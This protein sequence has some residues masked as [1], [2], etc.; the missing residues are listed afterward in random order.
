MEDPLEPRFEGNQLVI[1]TGQET[2]TYDCQFLVAVLLVY[3][4][5][6]DG[7]ITAEETGRML[8]LIGDHFRLRSAESL[9]L[10]RRAMTDIA[11][12]PDLDSLLRELS[13]M[14]TDKDRQEV[15][16]MMVKVLAA[17]GKSD[18]EEMER[19]REAGSLVGI[20]ARII[21]DAF[22]RYF[23]ETQTGP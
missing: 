20:R 1:E 14:L 2:E 21:H 16:L 15:A 11:E 6:A 4:A 23:A 18:A 22:D 5:K 12:N 10:L 8:E 9:E 7:D 19:M 3:V 13:T 17:D